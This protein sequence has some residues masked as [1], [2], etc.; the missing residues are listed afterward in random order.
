MFAL[1]LCVCCFGSLA[2]A[3]KEFSEKLPVAPPIP[4]WPPPEPQ[5]T[6]TPPDTEIPVDDYLP[7]L[8]LGG[9]CIAIVHFKGVNASFLNEV[10]NKNSI[11][12]K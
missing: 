6:P 5:F 12:F 2:L 10:K 7:L 1:T 8:I 9:V 3:Q 11:L 4:S